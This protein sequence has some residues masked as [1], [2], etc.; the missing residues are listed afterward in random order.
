M[1]SLVMGIFVMLPELR[2]RIFPELTLEMEWFIMM[3]CEKCGA[4]MADDSLFCEKCG[5]RAAGPQPGPVPVPPPAPTPPPVNSFQQ[6][7][8]QQN[9]FQQPS[10]GY[11]QPYQNY[12]QQN[13]NFQQP[14]SS[15]YY[16]DSGSFISSA[17]TEKKSNTAIIVALTAL[18]VLVLALC[19]V[20]LFMV[21]N[22]DDDSS[23]SKNGSAVEVSDTAA[24]PEEDETEHRSESTQSGS[25][26][27]GGADPVPTTT[28]APEPPDNSFEGIAR[29]SSERKKVN[30]NYV[31]SDVSDYPNVKVYFTAEDDYGN[32][33]ELTSPNV[34]IK[35]T[36][37]GGQEIEREIKSVEQ[38]KGRE[39]VS[40]D[41]IADK[42][43]SM[44]RDLG[45]M[46]TVM[47][48]FID[49]LDYDSGDRA[50]LIAFDSFVMYMCTYTC[51]TTLLKNGI[52]NMTAAGETALYD[53]LYEGVENAGA[54]RGARCVIA[55][56]DGSD[57][58][59]T[60]TA[61]DVINRANFYSVPVFIIGTKGASDY[62]NITSA[63]GGS[64]WNI[65]NI[66]DMSQILDEIYAQEKD[67]YCLEYVSDGSKDRYENRTVDMALEDDNYGTIT[68]MN[69]TPTETL[70]KQSHST[71]YEVIKAD[72]TWEE[73]NTE[74]IKRGGHL[75]TIT[76]DAEMQQASKLAADAGLKYVWMGGYTSIRGNG[77]FGHW[78]T[79][80]EFSYQQW[81][82]GEPSRNDIDGVPEMYL[83]LWFVDNKWSWN[84]QRNDVCNI[85]GLTYFKGATGYICEY[86]D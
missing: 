71:R 76:S 7:G 11:Q 41:I 60:H 2:Y 82:P 50:E 51:D 56:T 54:Q 6:P 65:N 62:D 29:R 32:T 79:G 27:S 18:T 14:T 85:P 66:S 13:Q 64:Y 26:N 12:Q 77:A 19:G 44:Q 61:D 38:L 28:E 5:N 24:D 35:E 74:C 83:M 17:Q 36:V 10:N 81:Y 47:R 40:F 73:A 34:A 37:K 80:E 53:A 57:N 9:P 70:Q 84:D 8:V 58:R 1:Q 21:L 16:Q 43:G 48:E 33:V 3:F 55:F 63:T 23:G 15:G 30:I 46:Q 45:D 67:M 20:L 52:N 22:K 75:I 31:S 78:I 68:Q 49:A 25:L 42:S 86:E 69:F 59:S 39:G 72:I 4:P